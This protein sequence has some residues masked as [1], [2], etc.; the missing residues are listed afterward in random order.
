[1]SPAAINRTA[2]YHVV[3][4]TANAMSDVVKCYRYGWECRAQAISK[5]E[6][7]DKQRK[8]ILSAILSEDGLITQRWSPYLQRPSHR[9]FASVVFFDALYTLFG[10]VDVMDYVFVLDLTPVTNPEWHSPRVC[11]LYEL[12]F[13]RVI[14]S[15]AKLIAISHDTARA[16]WASYG[17]P[18]SEIAVLH[19]YQ[20]SNLVI[21]NTPR[22]PKLLLFVGSLETRKNVAGLIKAFEITGLGRHGYR[23]VIAGGDAHGAEEIR[24]L[25]SAI[26]G[27]VLEGFVTD[28]RLAELYST[29]AAFIY[30]SFLEGFGVPLLEA[31]SAGLPVV[32]SL[33]GAAPEVAGE[34]ALL[35]DP[36]D[37]RDIA[38]GIIAVTSRTESELLKMAKQG[39]ARAKKFTFES[40]IARFREIVRDGLTA[41]TGT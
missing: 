18:L 25:A 20:R 21:G 38:K 13:R 31:M 29:A 35:V 36:Y 19:L 34:S 16:L 8:S 3:H 5:R 33:T 40:Y 32:A 23:L 11:E 26:E 4:D 17:V 22:D 1:M 37:V 14:A 15:G 9:D 10:G 2:M 24:I 28:Q 39:I 6:E 30:P 12:A 7:L 41:G 27:V